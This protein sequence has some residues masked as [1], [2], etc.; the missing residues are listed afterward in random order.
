MLYESISEFLIKLASSAPIPGGGGAS[1]LGGT[2]GVALGAMVGNLTLGKQ[3]YAD[4]QEDIIILLQKMDESIQRLSNLIQK[5]ADVFEP[6]SKAYA[7][8]NETDEQK[9]HKNE[10]LEYSLA[11]ACQVP[12]EIMEESV[13][14]LGLLEEMA[15]KGT[16]LAVSDVG[17]GVQLL[18]AAVFG[19]AMN[20]YVNTKLMKNRSYA[21]NCNERADTLKLKGADIADRVYK[22]IE[23]V[24]MCL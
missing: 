21:V 18:R 15:S 5:D 19:G 23:E 13:L 20:V 16:R 1:A 24:L 4:V 14:A 11:N 17:V 12:L 8:P 7:L 6:L 9:L 2:I 3:K 10:I 22:N